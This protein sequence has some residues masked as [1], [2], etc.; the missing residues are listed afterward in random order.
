VL[1]RYGPW[2]SLDD[3]AYELRVLERVA[4]LGWPVPLALTPPAQVGPHIWGLFRYLPG[5]P[6]RPRTDAALRTEQRARGRLLA[7]LHADLAG[8]TDLGQRPGWRRREAVLDPWPHGPSVEEVIEARVAPGDASVM[9]EYAGRARA[10]FA[11]LGAAQ[12]P[13]VVVHGDL[14]GSNTLYAR[15]VLSGVLDFD[16][17]HLDLRVADF[18]WTWRGIHDDFVRGYEE[19]T[20]LT[21]VERALLAPAFWAT[22][23]DSARFAGAEERA[24]AQGIVLTT[25]GAEVA[26]DRAAALRKLHELHEACR[27]DVP[28]LDPP[29]EE[30]YEEVVAWWET[31]GLVSPTYLPDGYLIARDGQR[32]VG[33]SALWDSRDEPDALDQGMT[34]VIRAYRGRGIATALKVR[35][36]RQA[37]SLGKRQIRTRNDSLN[38]AMLRINAAMGFRRES[39]RLTFELALST[40]PDT[41]DGR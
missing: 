27:R 31:V 38:A 23:L 25:L 6:R 19:V 5:R 22:V 29:T 8:L 34:G 33:E 14:I 40:V 20:P 3:V 36:V 21:A 17:T 12:L 7:R 24:G 37:R 15:G 4:A 41:P 18:V 30:P 26:R 10:R 1:R 2:H 16:L 28:A 32:W 13:A 39:A 9:L 35:G 11:A